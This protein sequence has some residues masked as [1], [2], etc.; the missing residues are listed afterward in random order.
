MSRQLT[1]GEIVD[2]I[3]AYTINLE[4]AISI[5]DRYKRTRQGI[6]KVLKKAGVDVAKSS[7]IPVTC[8]A[9]GK[10]IRRRRCEVRTRKNLFCDHECYYAFL[11]AG[12]GNPSIQ[13]RHGQRIG[14]DVVSGLFDLKPGHVVHHENRNNYDNRPHNLRVFANNGDHIRYHRLG[15]DYVQPIWDGSKI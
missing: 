12:N 15:S 10:E 13:N 9:C 4:P 8:P 11:Q 6:Y 7:V 5:A 2:V 1:P 3:T 14:R